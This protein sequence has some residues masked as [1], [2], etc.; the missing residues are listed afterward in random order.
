MFGL[1]LIKMR[2]IYPF[3]VVGRGGETQLQ[4]GENLNKRGKCNENVFI[5]SKYI[6]N[7]INSRDIS[8]W[9]T[10]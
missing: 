5:Q 9:G 8:T 10:T 3:E 6:L 7:F 2:I 1:E 4:V